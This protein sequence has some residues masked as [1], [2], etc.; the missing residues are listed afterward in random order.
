MVKPVLGD[1][2]AMPRLISIST[3]NSPL[4]VPYSRL[5]NDSRG[6]LSRSPRS[7]PVS[8]EPTPRLEVASRPLQS[9]QPPKRGMGLIIVSHLAT[10]VP[11]ECTELVPRRGWVS[12]SVA[13][14]RSMGLPDDAPPPVLVREERRRVDPPPRVSPVP[15]RA[16]ADQVAVPALQLAI[17][18]AEG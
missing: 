5:R 14:L 4:G 18:A 12:P 10:S 17:A 16:A 9:F 2:V 15:G 7:L 1:A 11:P 8:L 6:P 13:S 3:R